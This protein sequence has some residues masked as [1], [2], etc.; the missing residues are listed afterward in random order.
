MDS[1]IGAAELLK[2]AAAM[3]RLTSE[4]LLIAD[5]PLFVIAK[6]LKVEP[7]PSQRNY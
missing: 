2:Y 1:S 6:T 7:K 5:L 4:K 3:K